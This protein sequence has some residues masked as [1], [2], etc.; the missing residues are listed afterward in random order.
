MGIEQTVPRIGR[1]EELNR[2]DAKVAER[3]K[4]EVEESWN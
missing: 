2:Q 3:R 1:C 4:R